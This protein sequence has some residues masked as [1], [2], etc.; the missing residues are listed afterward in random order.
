MKVGVLTSVH[1]A[2]DVRIF[3]KEC[4][5]LARAGHDVTLIARHGRDEVVAGVRIIGVPGCE[6]HRLRRA[7]A[8][9]WRVYREALRLD[10]TVYHLHDPE[11]LPIGLLLRRRGKQVV[12]DAHEDLPR[13]IAS[14]AYV[15]GVLHSPVALLAGALERLVAA[16]T[17][18]ADRFAATNPC[19]L[20]VRNYA[21][22][23]DWPAELQLPW[24]E[25]PPAVA[26]VGAITADRGLREMVEAIALVPSTRQARL[27]LAG[28][29]SPPG[30]R[31]EAARLVGWERV[32]DLGVLGRDEVAVLLG[33]VRAGLVVLH[34][35]PNYLPSLPIKL[36]EYMAAG[37]P[38]IA[39][40]FPSLRAIIQEARCG[41][42]VDPRRPAAVAAAIEFLLGHPA[43]AGAMGRRGRE[44][45]AQRY[46]WTTEERTLLQLYASLDRPSSSAAV[47]GAGPSHSQGQ[48]GDARHNRPSVVG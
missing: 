37:L 1:P 28:L 24:P 9:V 43:E 11:L 32:D 33:R 41:I 16:T 10:A 25:R 27:R 3:Y 2:L 20:V 18:I 31:D 22:M 47:A 5:S 44:A 21:I 23:A 8:T 19:T 14:K 4:C 35:T 26:Y 13:T 15:P 45:A 17:A 46:N 7:T 36:F 29:Y 30:L 42:L 12:Y 39:S 40:D 48:C 6:H 38:C 34:P